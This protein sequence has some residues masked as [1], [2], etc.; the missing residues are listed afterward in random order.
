LRPVGSNLF[1]GRD[2][3]TFLPDEGFVSDAITNRMHRDCEAQAEDLRV[4]IMKQR[5]IQAVL[6]LSHSTDSRKSSSALCSDAIVIE[7]VLSVL[8]NFL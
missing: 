4:P 5:L 1:V 8:F 6:M 2:S 7:R 3:R